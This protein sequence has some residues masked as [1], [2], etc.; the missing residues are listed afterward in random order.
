MAIGYVKNVTDP[1]MAPE[2]EYVNGVTT[3]NGIY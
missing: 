2:L 1:V 3:N